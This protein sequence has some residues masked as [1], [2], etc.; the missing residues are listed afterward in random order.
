MPAKF[1]SYIEVTFDRCSRTYGVAPCTAAVG[2]TGDQKCFNA[3]GSC[4]DIDNFNDTAVTLR[5]AVD[6]GAYLPKQIECIPSILAIDF[7][8][9]IVSLG[10]D[11]G[12]RAT[13]KV[14][15]RDHPDSDTGPAGD[16]YLDE[17]PPARDYNPWDQGTFWGKF[18]AR[19]PYLRGRAMRWI[20]GFLPD[21]FNGTY[22]QGSALPAGV[23]TDQEVRHY[24]IDSFDG[25]SPDGKYSIA[26]KDE[27]KLADGDR[28]QAPALSNGFLS[29]AIDDNDTAATLSPAGIGAEYAASGHVNLGGKEICSFTRSGDA[30]TLTRA[31]LNTAAVAH[32]AQVRVQQ[33]RRYTSADPADIVRDLL[34]TYAGVSSSLIPL[35]SWQAE[36]NAYLGT[37]YTG[38]IAEPTSVNK[39]ISEL[40]EQAALSIWW[41]DVNQQIQLRV[42]R[43]IPST[44]EA[45]SE[46][47]IIEGTLRVKDQPDK[48][49]SR[50]QTY[51]AQSNP[52]KK[53]DDLD[54]YL[55]TAETVDDDAEANY[56][57]AA[58]KQVFSRWI[59]L[60]G[61]SVA[62][63]LNDILNS[64]YV[65]PPRRF[66]FSLK[67]AAG[68][69]PVLGGG[70]QLTF[71]PFQDVTG[72]RAT[73][74]IQ[75]TS[76]KPLPDRFDVEAEEMLFTDTETDPSQR[77]IIIDTST[78]NLVLRA[79]HDQI[80]PAPE[81]GDT[82][83]LT[84]Q[85]GVKVGSLGVGTPALDVGSW[86][87]GVDITVIDNGTIQGRGGAGGK[88]GDSPLPQTGADGES[89]GTALYT[90]YAINLELPAASKLWGGGGGGAG[91]GASGISPYYGA[92][93]GGGGGAGIDGGVLGNRGASG[94]GYHGALGSAGTETAGG[95]AGAGGFFGGAGGAGGAPGVAGASGVAGSSGHPHGASAGGTGGAAGKQIDGVSFVTVTVNLGDRRGPTAN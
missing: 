49:I 66:N 78:Y 69:T 73:V 54:N 15:F 46:A 34:V 18:R 43:A 52:T 13:L 39:L 22:H 65:D 19:H 95:A 85:S 30:L 45:L 21:S 16:P 44:A 56:G 72:A 8:P 93:G 47:N 9:P 24:T 67:R 35:A 12:Q 62:E 14:T 70:H 25:P 31:Q 71:F 89:G 48:R 41:D 92:G 80:Y 68:V 27:L 7:T 6:A 88:G 1:L 75:I 32:D 3:I 82:V 4:Q 33:V 76:V 37:L 10:V 64:R 90:R 17:S 5:F 57:S 63:R 51:F 55:S 81:F 84:I 87:A 60:G 28:A 94:G 91:G 86:P 42:L 79:L 20:T 11:L 29:A 2:V 59:P 77:S 83:T 26:A 74:P 53:L 38:T 36:T 61:R 50:V 40:V 58:I 23:L